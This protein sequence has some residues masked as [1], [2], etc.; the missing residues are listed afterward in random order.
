MSKLKVLGKHTTRSGNYLDGEYSDGSK[1]SLRD[2]G[3]ADI[4]D[5]EEHVWQG[6]DKQFFKVY[7][8]GN[9]MGRTNSYGPTTS[10]I[11]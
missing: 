8:N 5:I 6:D 7:N 10:L 1:V 4:G 9:Y 2:Y 3:H 11:K